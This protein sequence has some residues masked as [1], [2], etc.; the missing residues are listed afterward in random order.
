MQRN[1]E[2][3]KGKKPTASHDDRLINE[4]IEKAQS[5]MTKLEASARPELEALKTTIRRNRITCPS[6]HPLVAEVSTTQGICMRCRSPLGKVSGRCP[7][8]RHVLCVVCVSWYRETGSSASMELTTHC[9][10]CG[11]SGT[12]MLIPKQLQIGDSYNPNSA[13]TGNDG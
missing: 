5:E 11:G 2:R 8:C 10:P 7:K 3:K 12:S 4:A 1:K 6:D 9:S 13:S